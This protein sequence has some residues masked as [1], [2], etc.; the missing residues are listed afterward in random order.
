MLG[1]GT[2]ESLRLLGRGV[3]Q[4]LR[5]A[6]A[7]MVQ[8]IARSAPIKLRPSAADLAIS[9]ACLRLASPSVER[10][11]HVVA[12]LADEKIMLAAAT[13]FWAVTRFGPSRPLRGEADQ[14]LCSVLIAGA[15]R[16]LCKRLVHRERPNRALARRH[17]TRVPRLGNAWDSF[18]SG[19]AMHLS[20]IGASAQRLLPRRWRPALWSGFAALAATRIMR[21]AHYPSDVIAG[22]GMGAL[23]NKAVVAMFGRAER[24]AAER[25]AASAPLQPY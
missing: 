23:I 6:K 14:M 12:W 9:N 11:L 15:I 22:L 24:A 4:A 25:A 10:P 1:K 18:P 20:A 7:F 3:R 17:D 8:I 16:H 21:L 2:R 5:I 13:A 19:H